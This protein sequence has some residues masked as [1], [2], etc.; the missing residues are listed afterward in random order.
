MKWFLL[1][2]FFIVL[3][4]FNSTQVQAQVHH[5]NGHFHSHPHT[6]YHYHH[7]YYPRVIGYQPIVR[8]YPSGTNLSVGPVNVLPNRSVRIQ[9]NSSFYR[10]EGYNIFDFRNGTF[11]YYPR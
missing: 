11:R 2:S 3:S 5:H 1:T 9:I 8:W 10:Y 7:Y 6:H 4:L